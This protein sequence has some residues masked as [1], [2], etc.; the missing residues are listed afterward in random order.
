MLLSSVLCAIGDPVQAMQTL[1]NGLLDF[2]GVS[3]TFPDIVIPFFTT[4]LDTE[5][6]EDL[7]ESGS[8]QLKTLSTL[9]LNKYDGRT[10]FKNWLA[11]LK[12]TALA[13]IEL[14]ADIASMRTRSIKV[15]SSRKDLSS[16]MAT[17]T[18]IDMRMRIR[19][20]RFRT[21]FRSGPGGDRFPEHV[22][23]VLRSPDPNRLLV[24]K[25]IV[26]PHPRGGYGI[27][28]TEDIPAETLVLVENPMFSFNDDR[29]GKE[30]CH[31]CHRKIVTV[32]AC[33]RC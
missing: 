4:F 8:L 9:D 32:C 7:P 3:S 28:A 30:L 10:D 12:T 5:R 24:Q 33:E 11:A 29:S 22:Q 25:I 14:Q 19:K 18:L 15:V 23:S 13:L 1:S 26:Q 16:E 27:F 2:K 31:H 17:N 6:F 21:E 20:S